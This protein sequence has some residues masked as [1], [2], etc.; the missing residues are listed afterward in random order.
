MYIIKIINIFTTMLRFY[1]NKIQ[2][3]VTA[4]GWLLSLTH[5]ILLC[6]KKM[7]KFKENFRRTNLIVS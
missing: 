3:D 1:E 7:I 2:V 5:R 4:R 6:S